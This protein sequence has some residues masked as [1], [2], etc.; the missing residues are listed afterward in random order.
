MAY[1]AHDRIIF[2][3]TKKSFSINRNDAN[4]G[5]K[6]IP[7]LKRPP[8]QISANGSKATPSPTVLAALEKSSVC[9]SSTSNPS[10]DKKLAEYQTRPSTGFGI[11]GGEV[12]V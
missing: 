9:S 2:H 7:A 6:V 1:N 12:I 11:L 5:I 10:V 8:I 4:R 3:R